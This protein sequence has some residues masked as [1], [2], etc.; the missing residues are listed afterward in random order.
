M[1]TA[2][3]FSGERTFRLALPA[4]KDT[5]R[6][7]RGWSYITVVRRLYAEDV[8]GGK[9][10]CEWKGRTSIEGEAQMVGCGEGGGGDEVESEKEDR[11]SICRSFPT[12]NHVRERFRPA[13][14]EK[15]HFGNISQYFSLYGATVAERLSRS[16]TTEVN[17]ARSP[18]RWESHR[19]KMLAG[20]FSRGGGEEG[21]RSPVYPAHSFQRRSIFTSIIPIGSQD[22]A[23]K[24]RPNLFTHSSLNED[25]IC[26]HCDVFW[27]YLYLEWLMAFCKEF[28]PPSPAKSVENN[29]GNSGDSWR[30]SKPLRPEVFLLFPS[31]RIAR[32]SESCVLNAAR[33]FNLINVRLQLIKRRRREN[34]GGGE[35]AGKE[36]RKGG[37]GAGAEGVGREWCFNSIG[38]N[39]FKVRRVLT[40]RSLS[41]FLLGP[42]LPDRKAREI[43]KQFARHDSSL[44]RRKEKIHYRPKSNWAP[45]HNVCSVVVTPLESRKATFFSYE[46]RHPFWHARYEYLQEIHVDSSPFLLQPFHELSNGFWPRLTSPRPAIQFV[47][48]MFYRVEVGTLGRPIQSANIVVGVPLHS[49]PRNMAPGIVI[50]EVTRVHSVKTPQ[51]WEHF[52]IQNVTIGLCVHATTDRHQRPY[53]EGRETA[54]HHHFTTT[55]FPSWHHTLRHKPFPG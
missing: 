21:G 5:H 38:C 43:F 31:R 17:R 9:R 2:R 23:D 16:P 36:R 46:R 26:C 50:L 30:P 25:G 44:E 52:I 48:N 1:V 28:F 20:G 8:G 6:A 32:H 13:F 14:I 55:E 40:R 22:L 15:A 34:L 11:L 49:N 18:G 53:A 7:L 42:T 54:P 4:H 33:T 45:V 41:E 27:G 24:S 10:S 39:F 29:F 19:T 51:C 12:D 37:G 35:E 47:P 3:S